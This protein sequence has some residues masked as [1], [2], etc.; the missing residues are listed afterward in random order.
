VPLK[1]LKE[2]GLERKMKWPMVIMIMKL[3]MRRRRLDSDIRTATWND[4]PHLSTPPPFDAR[5]G[6]SE[7]DY[8]NN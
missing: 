8:G 5:N 3:I 1:L 7:V 2:K 4:S 6:F